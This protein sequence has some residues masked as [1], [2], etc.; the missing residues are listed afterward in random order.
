MATAT[1]DRVRKRRDTLRALGLRPIQ[2]WAP[3]TRRPGFAE[4]C[5]RQSN[6]I[7]EAEKNDPE[8]A[9]FMDAALEDLVRSGEWR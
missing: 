9:A 8:L 3:D 6:L 7:A 1:V 4:E 2:I 5:Q